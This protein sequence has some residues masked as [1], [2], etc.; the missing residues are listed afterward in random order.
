MSIQLPDC[1]TLQYVGMANV[2]PRKKTD[3]GTSTMHIISTQ[4]LLKF[5]KQTNCIQFKTFTAT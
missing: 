2:K 3:A 1:Q 5:F 4:L